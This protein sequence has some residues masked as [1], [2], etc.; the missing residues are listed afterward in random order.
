MPNKEYNLNFE[1]LGAFAFPEQWVEL[2]QNHDVFKYKVRFFDMEID[3]GT[4]FIR[5]LTEEEKK[6]EDEKNPKKKKE[7]GKKKKGEEDEP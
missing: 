6:A 7:K 3:K 4:S 5:M 2:D 1:V